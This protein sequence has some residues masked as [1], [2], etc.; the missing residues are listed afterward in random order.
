MAWLKDALKAFEGHVEGD[1]ERHA[2][3]ARR[4][5][6]Q[7]RRTEGQRS[8]RGPTRTT[9]RR[10]D[11]NSRWPS[12]C[13][14]SSKTISGT[15]CGSR[16]MSTTLR[17]PGMTR[18]ES[19]ICRIQ[20]VLGIRGGPINAGTFGPAELD[21]TLRPRAKVRQRAERQQAE[22][23][24]VRRSAVLRHRQDRRR[25]PGDAR[26]VP[27]SQW[28]GDLRARP[29]S[30]SLIGWHAKLASAAAPRAG[31]RTRAREIHRDAHVRRPA[32]RRSVAR[33]R[34]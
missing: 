6:R 14:S 22:S 21:L 13:A 1:C 16:P 3:F 27:R 26:V 28:Q 24:T 11:A 19:A 32:G 9:G 18:V 15:S 34:T 29:G 2:H 33:R 8:R 25:H 4:P 20:S 17:R 30:G 5:R 10:R 23:R 31:T 7:R 12:C